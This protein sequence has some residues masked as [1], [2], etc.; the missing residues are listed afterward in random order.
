M[1]RVG[2]ANLLYIV[3][4]ISARCWIRISFLDRYE[5]LWCSKTMYDMHHLV[6]L[7]PRSDDS[8]DK[9]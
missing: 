3:G 5:V 2:F 8:D 1:Y 6:L 4:G 7:R 9:Y